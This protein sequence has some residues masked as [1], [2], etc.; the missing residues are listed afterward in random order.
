VRVDLV[1]AP[2]QLFCEKMPAW[3]Y[4]GVAVKAWLALIILWTEAVPAFAETDSDTNGRGISYGFAVLD[5]NTVK[6]GRQRVR[7][8]GTDAPEKGPPC[9]DGHWY[10]GPLAKKALIAFIAA[11]QCRGTRLTMTTRITVPSRSTLPA[12]TTSRH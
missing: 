3:I 10:L 7:L 5:G 8:F 1:G 2:N 4:A 11:T 9:N 6:F 12:R